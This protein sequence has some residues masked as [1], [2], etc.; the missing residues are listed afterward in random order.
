MAELRVGV[1]RDVFFDPMP[2]IGVVAN[3]LAVG[4]D[5]QKAG[6]HPDV[7]Q[8][9]FELEDLVRQPLLQ[10]QDAR[11]RIEAGAELLRVDRLDEVFIG[12]GVQ[13]GDEIGRTVLRR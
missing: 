11:S 10:V 7:F 12:T 9:D 2:V 1:L 3:R 8:R 4:A 6:K 5:R 13:A